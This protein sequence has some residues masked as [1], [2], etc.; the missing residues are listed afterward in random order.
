MMLITSNVWA[1]KVQVFDGSD[2]SCSLPY[3]LAQD[4][5][6]YIWVG[7]THGLNRY[8]GYEFLKYYFDKNNEATISNN[9][10]SS[11][12]CDSEGRLWIGTNKGLCRYDYKTNTFIRYAVPD[13]S[14]RVSAIFQRKNGDLLI[15]TAGH[16]LFVL[17]KNSDELAKVVGPKKLTYDI[18]CERIYEDGKSNVWWSTHLNTITRCTLNGNKIEH[19]KEYK[20]ECG[21]VSD[22]I[23]LDNT[24]FLIACTHGVLSYNYATGM[25]TDAG[26]DISALPFGT[27]IITAYVN[28][29][30][31]IGIGTSNKG[32]FYI[33]VG[34]KT[35]LNGDVNGGA[36]LSNCEVNAMMSDA[37]GNSWIS[38]YRKGVVMATLADDVFHVFGNLSS[39]GK[40]LDEPRSSLAPTVFSS[41]QVQLGGASINLAVEKGGEYFVSEYGKGLLIFNPSKGEKT[42]MSMYQKQ[43]KGGYLT[44]DWI[45]TMFID[46]RQMLWIGTANGTSCMDLSDRTFNKYGW[47]EIMPDMKCTAI[48]ENLSGDILLGTDQGLY[49]YNRKENKVGEIPNSKELQT[50]IIYGFQTDKDGD[51]W[52]STSM[53]LWRWDVKKDLFVSYLNGNGLRR[54]EYL[55]N[56]SFCFTDGSLGFGTND[57]VVVFDPIDVK[58]TITDLGKVCL[59][60]VSIDN[61]VIGSIQDELEIHNGENLITLHYSLFNFSNNEDIMFQ[62]MINNSGEWVPVPEG[63]NAINFGRIKSGTYKIEVRACCNGVYSSENCVTTIK[64]LPPWYLSVWAFVL[65]FILAAGIV[66]FILR[67]IERRRKADYDEQKMQFLINAT[68]DIRSPLTLILGPL[69]KLKAK[70]TDPECQNDI[71]TIDHNAQRLLTLVN[72][73]LDERKIDKNQMHLHCQET[74]MV[75]FVK[76]VCHLYDFNA[77]ERSIKFS[78]S[79]SEER[80]MAWIDHTNF[81]KI[82]NNIISNAFKYT[83][84]GGEISVRLRTEDAD[85]KQGRCIVEVTD[86]GL[87]LQ[88]DDPEKLFARFYQGKNSNEYKIEGTGIGLNLSQSLAKM[89]GGKIT[90]ANR[91]DGV[92]GSVFTIAIPLGNAH[93]KEDEIIKESIA[94]DANRKTDMH[95]HQANRN[96]RVLVVDDDP[97]IA[98]FISN[99]LGTWYRFSTAKNG[100]EALSL[101]LNETFDLVISDV[102]MPV[103]DG[104]ELL[105]NVKSNSNISHVPVVM[106]TSKSAVD[107]RFEGLKKGADAYLSKP[108]D[109]EELHILIDNLVDNRRRL[110]GKFSGTQKAEGKVEEVNVKGN[111]EALMEQIMACINKH[112]TDPNFN[113]E[114]LSRELCIS[115]AQLFRRMKEIT[116]ISTSE[117]IRNLRLEQ[118]ARLLREGKINVSQVAYSVGFNSQTHFSTLF[119]K[120]FG[121]SPS[122]YADSSRE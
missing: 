22:F 20:S 16:G 24:G 70:I 59:S 32:F 83:F 55:P 50:L 63:S 82:L 18:F 90:A 80:I 98:D 33:P 109:M 39:V 120:H 105:K 66:A 122:E 101:L 75:H 15:G 10:I 121:K 65:Y 13:A 99:E 88:G 12:L 103:M 97:E 38:C 61:D 30:G 54:K 21:K 102:M 104:I 31:S 69:K 41:L 86:N 111:D 1:S 34:T 29:K 108:F 113:V 14:P 37:E 112:L 77:N 117:F 9:D 89:H 100:R 95:K 84:D 8:D 68:H 74:D 49:I 11:I 79:S 94:E 42:R 7:T 92:R 71:E 106:L 2:L 57:G 52:I 87:G 19:V 114:Q 118:S 23:K 28:D 26:Y 43:R 17:Q 78:F 25:I 119:K 5:F 56:S 85:C 48:G 36:D 62:Y 6:G 47:N 91:A 110:R 35:L 53:G 67:H 58:H 44:N 46:S 116:G 3:C 107:Y 60:S 73:I 96:L 115:R 93:L 64:V 27:E 81:D 40:P 72:Q 51:V 76:N 4:K 45:N